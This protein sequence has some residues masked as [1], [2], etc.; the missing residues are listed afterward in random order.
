MT[1]MMPLS[2]FM[3]GQRDPGES[4]PRPGLEPVYAALAQEWQT[5]GRLVPGRYDEEWAV[6]AR[7]TWAGP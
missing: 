2:Q 6:L 5:A 7:Y 1:T 3:A 4:V